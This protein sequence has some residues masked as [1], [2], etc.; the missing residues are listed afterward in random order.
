MFREFGQRRYRSE[1]RYTVAMTNSSRLGLSGL[2]LLAILS[3]C[4][5]SRGDTYRAGADDESSAAAA[6]AAASARARQ[7]EEA[8]RPSAPSYPSSGESSF[9][10]FGAI[11]ASP[12]PPQ[13][14]L[15]VTGLPSGAS[16]SIDGL[17]VFSFAPAHAGSPFELNPGLH[18]VE[19]RLFGFEDWE[20]DVVIAEDQTMSI[21]PELR[22]AAF[23][24]RSFG[25]SPERFNP[26]DPGYYG[27]CRL[28]LEAFA[29]G[30]LK[31]AVL[32]PAGRTLFGLGDR[33]M[34]RSDLSLTWNG[35]D[36]RGR[37]VPDGTYTIV[38]RDS[39]G[40]ELAR[41]AVV[42]D[43]SIIARSAVLASGAGG[44]LFVPAARAGAPGG[45][46]ISSFLLGHV[47]SS[48]GPTT[49]RILTG[50]GTRFSIP[51]SSSGGG[52]PADIEVDFSFMGI[53]HPGETA[54]VS[55]DAY[56]VC[57]ALLYP[58]AVEPLRASLLAK[59]TYGSF[60]DAGD[61][62][63]P[64]DGLARFPGLSVA[65]PVEYDV[66]TMRAFFAPEVEVGTFYPNYDP[67]AVPGFY[68]W[69]YLR[70]GFEA[71]TGPLSIALSGA[72]RSAPFD[73]GLSLAWPL[74]AGLELR[75]HATQSPLVLSFLLTGE[76]DSRSSWY[77][78]SGFSVGYRL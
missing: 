39:A 65:L 3:G 25:A 40:S 49:G 66:D 10:I 48:S 77:L 67:A 11:A 45:L 31:L 7:N 61:W 72:L 12:P 73:R 35:R 29:P 4:A 51:P 6:A 44:P 27:I 14:T 13:G 16:V 53:F 71:Q 28:S 37:P 9:S 59:F 18:H 64:Y 56:D 69:G 15:V 70:A 47:L 76:F 34:D 46:E 57:A 42:V 33:R 19:V 75:W 54:A 62:P 2:V 38:A 55:S 26:D 74:P 30:N 8:N 20:N 60:V 5:S 78:N 36:D 23:G 58:L 68:S 32:S 22:P 1:P 63:N 41:A 21:S 17:L 50:M 52:S 24:L 43:R